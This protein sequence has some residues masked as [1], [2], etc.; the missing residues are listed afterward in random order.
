VAI[1]GLARHI[2]G[3]LKGLTHKGNACEAVGILECHAESIESD[4]SEL[5]L[6]VHKADAN[7]LFGKPPSKKQQLS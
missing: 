6:S 1:E 7:F 5:V 4:V 2:K 3:V